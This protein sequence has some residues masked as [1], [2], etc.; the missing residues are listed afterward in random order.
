M[1]GIFALAL[2]SASSRRLTCPTADEATRTNEPWTMDFMSAALASGQKLHVLKV[3]IDA[4]VR[5]AA[6][7][8]AACYL[9][10]T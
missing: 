1:T 9:Y 4:R 3:R 7:I 8:L 6:S 2:E 10:V 5:R